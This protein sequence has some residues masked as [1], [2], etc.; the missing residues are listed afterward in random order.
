MNRLLQL[1][2]HKEADILN[3]YVTAGFPE[4]N[5]TKKILMDLQS[6]GVDLVELGIPYSDP[7]A[8][9]TTIQ[10]SSAKALKNGV[11]LK[12]I[13]D[14]VKEARAE[15]FTLPI[16][17]M[18]YFNQ[19]LQFGVQ[20]FLEECNDTGA[21]GLI[22]PDLPMN[23]YEKDYKGLF[24]QYKIGISFLIT[25]ATST[26]RIQQADRLSSGFI[27]IVSQSS[28][29]GKT[30]TITEE[31]QAYFQRIREMELKTPSL[32]GFGIHDKATYDMAC[33]QSNGAI[34][35][36]AFVRH[37]DRE[38]NKDNSVQNFISTIR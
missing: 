3:V 1:F 28:I 30:G 35:G 26:E 13:F 6:S 19:M 23:I 32:I 2:G 24:D 4:L 11:D 15:G 9:G 8:D 38:G 36:S 31:Q 33:A 5:S 34:I 22:I 29:T 25:P 12:Y 7:L 20:R 18:G 21:D 16:V 10:L 27:Y 14:T 37:L 17:L